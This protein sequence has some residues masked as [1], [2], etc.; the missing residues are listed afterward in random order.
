MAD[1]PIL[2]SF[3]RCPYAM[4]ARLALLASG[5]A[6][7]HREILL[8]AKPA[9]MLAA[10][11][12]GTVPVLI[13]PDG[14]V[15]DESLEIMRWALGRHDPEAWLNGDDAALIAINDGPFKRHLDRYKY[16]ER[17]GSDPI[18]HRTEAAGLL[19]ALDARL[20]KQAQLCGARRGMADM[21]IFPFVRQFAA[22][23]PEWF[24]ARPWAALRNWLAGHLGSDLFARAMVRHPLWVE[25]ETG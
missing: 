15:I 20:R 1:S 16:T 7:Q 22:V 10:S 11:P 5:Q 2:Y 25:T 21:A 24:A 19:D 4:R 6:V 8:R 23:E 3:R 12:K 13:L 14:R 9:A 17:H 18:A